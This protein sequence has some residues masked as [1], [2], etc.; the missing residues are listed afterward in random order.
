MEKEL[1]INTQKQK[2]IPISTAVN[3]GG[4]PTAN[5]ASTGGRKG[6]SSMKRMKAKLAEGI[7]NSSSQLNT[8]IPEETQQN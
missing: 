8:S 3:G 4:S 7:T 5:R 2:G 6:R 1:E